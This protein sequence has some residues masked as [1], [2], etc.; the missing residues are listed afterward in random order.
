MVLVFYINV[1][2]QALQ[3]V[4]SYRHN[5]TIVSTTEAALVI[6]PIEVVIKSCCLHMTGIEKVN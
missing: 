3:R 5:C 4:S 2:M 1:I 6:R